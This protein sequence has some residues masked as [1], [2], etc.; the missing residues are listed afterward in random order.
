MGA[1]GGVD[2]CVGATVEIEVV[3]DSE[4]EAGSVVVAGADGSDE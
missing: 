3:V 1:G 2:G 4:V